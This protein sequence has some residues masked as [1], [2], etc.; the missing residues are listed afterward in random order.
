MYKYQWGQH[1]PSGGIN[2]VIAAW[3]AKRPDREQDCAS[4]S[5]LMECPRVVWL[6]KHKVA[7]PFPLGWGKLQRFMLG[8]ITENTIASQL[9]DEGKLLWHWKDDAKGESEPFSHGEGLDKL[10]GTP[11][12]LINLYGKVAISDSKTSRADSFNYV[13]IMSDDIWKDPLWLKYKLQVT[14][15]YMLCHWNK[16]WFVE[17]PEWSLPL[18][19]VC[20]LFS[21]ALDDGIVRREITWNPSEEDAQEVMQYARRWN[22]AY[23]SEEMPPCVC[24]R[25]D[26]IRFCPYAQEQ[27]AT[28][29]GYKL[30]VR[31][32]G[33]EL[34]RTPSTAK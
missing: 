34:W 13:P 3:H 22:A 20:H 18:P 14:A 32:C 17:R 16:H 6:K 7:E 2:D 15:Y 28:K 23:L 1:I 30:G 33:E 24:E 26:K 10:K 5:T 9:R 27:T 12:L 19:E 31:C 21:Y 4:P 29:S 8:R 11:D 25:E